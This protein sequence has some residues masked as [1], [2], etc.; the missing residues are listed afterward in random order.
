M[1]SKALVTN[2]FTTFSIMHSLRLLS[3]TEAVEVVEES[4]E[5]CTEGRNVCDTQ[6]HRAKC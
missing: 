2:G 6:I 5:R 3:A 4:S 1:G